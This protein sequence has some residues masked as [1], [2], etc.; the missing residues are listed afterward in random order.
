MSKDDIYANPL[1]RVVDFRFDERV[2]G[3][4]PDMISRSVPG[5]AMF[6]HLIGILGAQHAQAGSR[7]YDL[8]CSLGAVTLAI[9]HQLRTEVR[10]I[11][12]VDNAPAM[13]ER[14]REL[15]A[16]DGPGPA[17]E[18][19]QADIVELPIEDAS[20]VVLNFTLQ[21]IPRAERMSLLERV[22]QG[23]RPDG[24]LILSEKVRFEQS[25]QQRQYEQWHEGFKRAQGYSD[26]EIAQ[27]RAALEQV[28]Q[29]ETEDTHRERMLGVGFRRVERIAQALNF[30]VFAAVK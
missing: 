10:E 7:V 12:A 27:K 3:V 1:H 22:Y 24:L 16:A 30:Q 17:V 4:F 15:I 19:R 23:L 29:P 21:F 25:L 18:V 8:G 6:V 5:Y 14:C 11:V 26:L 20:V 2:A 9:R 28:L 13:V